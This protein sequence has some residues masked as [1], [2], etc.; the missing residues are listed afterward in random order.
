MGKF[1]NDCAL[2]LSLLLTVTGSWGGGGVHKKALK[3]FCNGHSAKTNT[4]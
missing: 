2:P 3:S 1:S 4:D